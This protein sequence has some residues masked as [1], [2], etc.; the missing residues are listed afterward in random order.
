MTRT[1]TILG[2]T[3]SI[4]RSTIALLDAAPPGAFSVVALVAGRDAAGLAGVARRLRPA[5]A[6][7]ADPDAL[8][9][10]LPGFGSPPRRCPE[11]APAQAP[12]AP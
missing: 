10:L 11:P 7:L 5:V 12:P 8:P 2:A 3:G 4:G 6:V 1:V 9:A